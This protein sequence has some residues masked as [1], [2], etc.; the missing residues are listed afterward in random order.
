MGNTYFHRVQE[1]TAT[2]FWINNVT[3]E[4]AR[5][6]IEHGASGCT[7]NPSYVWKMI[8][9]SDEI[10]HVKQ[11]LGD[12]LSRC[13]DADKALI[14]LQRELVRE[15]AT[16]FRSVY[17]ASNGQDG[18]VSIQGDPFR[19][20][21]DSIIEF[22]RYNRDAGENILAKIPATASGLEAIEQLV[23]EY[24]PVNATE[25]MAVKQVTDVCA[26]YERVT[27]NMVRPA[28]LYFSVITGIFDEHLAN[29]VKR[30]HIDI[31]DDVL[32]QGGLIVAKKIYE[33]LKARRYQG[34]FVGGG[35]RG[36]HHFTEMVGADCAVTINWNGS[37][38]QLIES[39]PP[40]VSRF[41]NP[42]SQAA[43][44]E[45]TCKIPDFKKAYFP[46]EIDASEYEDFGPVALFRSQFEDAWKKAKS[47]IEE[48]MT[49]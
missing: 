20:D 43:L 33:I 7:Q 2:R 24:V 26:L 19:E 32:W 30:D 38:D 4:Q 6:S 12:I 27:K 17:D 40:V 3:R 41:F 1:Q 22:A 9:S 10:A 46:H 37:A 42:V 29:T 47:F 21:K 15:I 25:C 18:Y 13:K 23:S 8:N 39:N 34:H 35:A 31:S 36:L 16:I 44:D 49:I 28:P 11:R 14:E 45:L 5:L 48:S